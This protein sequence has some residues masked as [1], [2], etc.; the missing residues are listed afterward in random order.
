MRLLG[1]TERRITKDE[2]GENNPGMEVTE[3]ALFHCNLVNNTYH[4]ESRVLYTFTLNKSFGSLI[5]I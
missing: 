2:N 3:V 1:S 4:Y 5:D